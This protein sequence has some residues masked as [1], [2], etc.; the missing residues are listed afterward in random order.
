[1]FNLGLVAL[2]DDFLV[3]PSPE[4]YLGMSDDIMSIEEQDKLLSQMLEDA[5]FLE[6]VRSGRQEGEGVVLCI[7]PVYE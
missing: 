7:F 1:M 6:Q 5:A 4:D 2:P 3:L